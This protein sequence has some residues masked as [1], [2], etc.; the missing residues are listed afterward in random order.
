MGLSNEEVARILLE[1][2]PSDV[3]DGVVFLGRKDEQLIALRAV[4]NPVPLRAQAMWREVL[5]S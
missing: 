4:S 1:H 5:E 3:Y 2:L